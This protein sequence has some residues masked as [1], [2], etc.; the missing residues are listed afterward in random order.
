MLTISVNC[1][2]KDL[3]AS[4]CQMLLNEASTLLMSE[5]TV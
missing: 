4:T 1:R 5:I 2:A 3:F